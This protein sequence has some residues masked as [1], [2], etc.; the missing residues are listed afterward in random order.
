[1]AFAAAADVV[2]ASDAYC[3]AVSKTCA[4]LGVSGRGDWSTASWC[5][6]L[7]C[8]VDEMRRSKST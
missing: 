6:D 3:L 7:A 4:G 1:M 8:F 2:G 5:E